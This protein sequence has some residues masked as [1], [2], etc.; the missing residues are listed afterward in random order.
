M[1]IPKS[2]GTHDG[3]F[4]ADEVTACALLLCYGLI[5]KNKVQR[6][7]KKEILDQC[8]YVCDVG[9]EYDPSRKKFDHHQISYKGSFSSAG[10]IWLY[11]KDTKVI[12]YSFYAFLQNSLIQGVDAHDNGKASLEPGI[13]SF[14]QIISNFAPIHY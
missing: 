12:D 3:T 10:M 2:F 5:D 9:G 8:E 14:S 7:R 6:T 11:L 13:C 1:V 4:H